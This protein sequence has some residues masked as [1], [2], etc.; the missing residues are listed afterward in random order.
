MKIKFT[1]LLFL[2]LVTFSAIANYN[3][4][5]EKLKKVKLQLNNKTFELCVPKGYML[6]IN[7]TT[8]EKL[9]SA[10]MDVFFRNVPTVQQS[11]AFLDL[12]FKNRYDFAK[13]AHSVGLFLIQNLQ[14]KKHVRNAVPMW[15]KNVCRVL[16]AITYRPRA[17]TNSGPI[18]AFTLQCL[19]LT[20]D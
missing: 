16:S 3:L 19:C 14:S 11:E 15:R 12:A 13:I 7:Y 9:L 1:L 8:E 6:S 17:S 5:K 4:P 10:G 20:A 2:L 18:N